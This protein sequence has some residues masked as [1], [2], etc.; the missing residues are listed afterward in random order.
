MAASQIQ[1]INLAIH[2]LGAG[3][4]TA[5]TDGSKPARVMTDIY[6]LVRQAELRRSRWNF[7]IARAS[8]GALAAVPAFGFG[9][10]YQ[11]PADYLSL[12]QAGDTLA[13]PALSNYV[14]DDNS[15]W[16]I[17]SGQ[18]LTDLTAPLRIR[19]VRNVTDETQ[20]DALFVMALAARLAYEACEEITGANT[21][22]DAAANDY[23]EALKQAVR[24]NAIERA[25]VAIA[26]DSWM[27]GRL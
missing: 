5:L 17:E 7:S 27:V 26:D 19:Y 12:I 2:K 13:A 20:F 6:D 9:Y 14:T 16:S 22:K 21:K 8:L 1:I 10:A 25:P 24:A 23:T 18:I 15:Q 11:L 4:I 3:R